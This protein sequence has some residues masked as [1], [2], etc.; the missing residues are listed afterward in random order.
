MKVNFNRAALAEALGLLTSVIPSRTPKPV[1]RCVKITAGKEKDTLILSADSDVL[2]IEIMN[3]KGIK[4]LITEQVDKTSVKIPVIKR[5]FIKQAL[6]KVGFP[7]EDLA[8]Y[9]KGTPH[10]FNLAPT[11][12]NGEPFGIRDY[13]KDAGDIF[14]ASGSRRGGSGVIVLPCGAGKTMVGIGIMDRLQT[15]TLI[16]CPNVIAVRQWISELLDKT[17]LTEKDVG[18]YTGDTK[19][20]KPVTIATYQI[21][22][23]RRSREG[24][25]EHFG[26]FEARNWGLIIYDEVHLAFVM[27]IIWACGQELKEQGEITHNLRWGGN[28]DTDGVIALDRDQSFDDLPH[29]ELI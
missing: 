21:L 13:Q 7:V 20:V 3:Q 8:G 11:C 2:M 1:L 17:S 28:W 5:G 4:E 22:T 16:L 26:I 27:G 6:I 29:I 19:E 25:F 24:D 15:S 9:V 10:P 23:W 18:E 12:R 14:F